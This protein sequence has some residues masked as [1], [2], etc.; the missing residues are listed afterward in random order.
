[1]FECDLHVHSIRSACGFHTL[2]EIVGIMKAKG[3]RGFALTDHG[4]ALN[5]PRSHF[6][7][8]L[9][10]LPAEIDGVRVFKGIEASVMT[11]EGDL[12]LPEFAGVSYEVIVAGLH[13]HDAFKEDRGIRANTAALVR[14]MRKNPGISIISHPYYAALP[15]DL[16]ELTDAACEAGVALEINNSHILID[17]ADTSRLARMLELAREKGTPLTVDS[18]GHVLSEMGDFTEAER[19]MTPYGAADLN[20]VNRT[21]E[22]TLVFLGLEK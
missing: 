3:L 12:D 19:V 17:K 22:S 9:R 18:D 6:S 7:V 21:M 16:D 4:P 11:E 8:L 5:T 13:Q 2:L 20:I 10:R 14:A 1:M 15:V